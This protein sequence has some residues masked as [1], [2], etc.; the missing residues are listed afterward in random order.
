MQTL[1]QHNAVHSITIY[2][3]F[4]EKQDHDLSHLRAIYGCVK[5][6]SKIM[7]NVLLQKIAQLS[8]V[9]LK[10]DK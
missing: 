5:I 8:E 1:W 2:F 4:V 7:V 10:L 9:N 6:T 3:L